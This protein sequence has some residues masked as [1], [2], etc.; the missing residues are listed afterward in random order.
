MR[1]SELS[2]ATGVSVPTIKFYLREGLVPPGQALGR[3]RARYG[4]QH[5]HRLR[6]I[7]ALTEVGELSLRDVKAVLRAADDPRLSLHRLLGTAQY[8]LE[9]R[10]RVTSE[11]SAA[12][13]ARTL[14]DRVLDD[15]GWRVAPQAPGRATLAH[16]IA[17]LR[18]LGWQVTPAGLRRYARAVDGLARWEVSV[19]ADTR[20]REEAVERMV[21][22]TVLFEAILTAFRRLA[23]EHHSAGARRGGR[24]RTA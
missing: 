1:I 11:P 14:V 8:V 3:T 7:R 2:Q 12:A 9:P 13:E 18:G 16:A 4:E 19:T 17:T 15:L 5:V 22:G 6:L 10:P 20:D 23:Q 24:R 21:I